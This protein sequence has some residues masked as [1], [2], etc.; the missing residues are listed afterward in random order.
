MGMITATTMTIMKNFKYALCTLVAGAAM[1]ACSNDDTFDN[2][3]KPVDE[4]IFTVTVDNDVTR[5]SFTD[6]TGIVWDGD[7]HTAFGY[8][9]T[10]V[11]G[12]TKAS[13]ISIDDTRAAFSFNGIPSGSSVWFLYSKSMNIFGAKHEITISGAQTQ[14]RPGTIGSANLNFRSDV[15]P[16]EEGA[17]TAEPQ[18]KLV[19]TLQRFL[20]YSPTGAYKDESIQSIK[21]TAADNIAGLMGYNKEGQPIDLNANPVEN[22][23]IYWS[24]TNTITT[25]VENPSAVGASNRDETLGH[26]IYMSVAP[27]NVA[28]GYTYVITTDK[29]VY[30]LAGPSDKKFA[31]GA[32]LNIFVNL[33]SDAVHR[34]GND[35]KKGSLRYVGDFG[36]LNSAFSPNAAQRIDGGYW[37]AQTMELADGSPWIVRE[38]ADYPEFYK[39]VTFDIIDDKTGEPADWINVYYM[40]N[41]THWG[42]DLLENTSSEPRSATVTAHYGDVN[43]WIIVP[44]CLTKVVTVKQLC[45]TK[46]IPTIGYTGSP[47]IPKE[48]ATIEATLK[49]TSNGVELTGNDFNAYISQVEISAVNASIKRDGQK[50]TI[51]VAKNM[52]TTEKNIEV[53]AA[54]ADGSDTLSLTQ[55]AGDTDKVSA[56]TYSFGDWQKATSTRYFD[57]GAAERPNTEWMAVIFNIQKDGVSPDSLTAE[58]EAELVK[59]IL[60]FSDEEFEQ[61]FLTFKIEYSKYESKI[62]FGVKENTTGAARTV[63]G[64]VWAWDFSYTITHY[65]ITQNAQ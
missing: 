42:I 45:V 20:V 17:T 41:S 18:M 54:T 19:G 8:I 15:M 37:Y 63:E 13:A 11:D 61:T 64:Y 29:A 4:A 21:M 47:V 43:G 58:D 36:A 62:L 3:E 7:D 32:L 35:E 24:Q 6:G 12:C 44:E 28:A 59:Q 5:T 40:E 50:L 1:V 23:T 27:V 25:T 31:N 55:S 14:P 39:D 53:T 26:G 10:A 65:R 22:E 30:T 52:H 57:W 51:T 38:H 2:P 33:E 9:N 49:L 34:V 16:I 48:G 60:G 46:L 56:F